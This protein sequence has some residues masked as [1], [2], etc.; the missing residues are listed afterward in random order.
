MITEDV[1]ESG[2]NYDDFQDEMNNCFFYEEKDPR[3]SD[4]SHDALID[5]ECA[6]RISSSHPLMYPMINRVQRRP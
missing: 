5:V 2:M 6:R 3:E 1:Y 4:V